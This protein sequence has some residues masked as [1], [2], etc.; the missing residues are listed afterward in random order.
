VADI[1]APVLLVHQ[2]DDRAVPVR[3]SKAMRDALQNAG[4]A[5]TYVELPG[6]DHELTTEE[7]RL[8]TA[9]AVL[10]FL[11]TYNPAN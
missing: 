3:Q 6:S 10:S 2:T 11:K 9:E 8:A 7:A 1:K 5:V 4:K